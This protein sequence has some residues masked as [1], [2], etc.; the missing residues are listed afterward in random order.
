MF[1]GS[2]HIIIQGGTFIVVNGGIDSASLG[3]CPVLKFST[4]TKSLT[5][6]EAMGVNNIYPTPEPEEN[7]NRGRL[8]PNFRA[9]HG[10]Q[11]PA[12]T[13]QF[14]LETDAEQF[15]IESEVDPSFGSR[16]V[17]NFATPVYGPERVPEY[18]LYFRPPTPSITSESWDQI[19]ST[20][21]SVMSAGVRGNTNLSS[22]DSH[23]PSCPMSN[24]S[25]KSQYGMSSLT[26]VF[27]VI[28]RSD[29]FSWIHISHAPKQASETSSPN[30]TAT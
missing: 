23:V 4:L 21:M 22:N 18:D 7:H 6:I 26:Q 19:T 15:I 9:S 3:R 27:I 14:S 16:S 11:V 25:T 13:E 8:H 2:S 29:F 20:P 24:Y 12:T 17:M 10:H 1:N 30:I 5:S 28:C